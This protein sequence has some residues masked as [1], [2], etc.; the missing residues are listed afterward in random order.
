MLYQ[1]GCYLTWYFNISF[2]IESKGAYHLV[3]FGVIS[4]WLPQEDC[5]PLLGGRKKRD[6]INM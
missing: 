3:A 1:V 6:N 4:Y 5:K 2:R